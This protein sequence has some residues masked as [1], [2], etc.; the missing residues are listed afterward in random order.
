[1]VEHRYLVIMKE[2]PEAR[3]ALRFAARRAAKTDRSVEVLAIIEPQ[4]FAA[5][6]GVQAAMEEEERLRMEATI[7]S[8][9]GEL[10]EET[11]IKPHI[12]IRSGDS[13]KIIG[14]EI[15]ERNDIAA[16]V[17]GAAPGE[18]PGPIVKYFTGEGAGNLPCPVLIIPGVLDDERIELLS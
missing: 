6:G 1:M 3:V 11:G 10:I 4:N 2:A 5:F 13:I 16:L 14:K 12:T 15:S 18:N 7:A 9:V 17:L 8:T